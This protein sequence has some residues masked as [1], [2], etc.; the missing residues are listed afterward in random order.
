[1]DCSGVKVKLSFQSHPYSSLPET[2]IFLQIES[3]GRYFVI[4]CIESRNGFV[5]PTYYLLQLFQPKT[6]HATLLTPSGTGV[7][8]DQSRF[9][10][11]KP[12]QIASLLPLKPQ[13]C[14]SEE[15]DFDENS[16]ITKCRN[17]LKKFKV[18]SDFDD[19]CSKNAQSVKNNATE[20]P[21][22]LPGL[23]NVVSSC[24][25][26]FLTNSVQEAIRS[27]IPGAQFFSTLSEGAPCIIITKM[28]D[29]NLG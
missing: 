26:R 24:Y 17:D 22:T 29:Y 11:Y 7:K 25:V 13:K 8:S 10:A 15:R 1:M 14:S 16:D 27:F 21:L 2:K 4:V 18:T 12:I 23:R 3:N 28:P 19:E 6:G 20:E 5:Q 9:S